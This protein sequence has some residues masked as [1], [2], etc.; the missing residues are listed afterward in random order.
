MNDALLVLALKFI[1]ENSFFLIKLVLSRKI[2]V[3]KRLTLGYYYLYWYRTEHTLEHTVISKIIKHIQAFLLLCQATVTLKL[4][5]TAVFCS[6]K[7]HCE[8]RN[9]ASFN[10]QEFFRSV[11]LETISLQRQ[12]E[13]KTMAERWKD[14]KTK[15]YNKLHHKY[16]S[17]A[18]KLT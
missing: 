2:F 10:S 3:S 16:V 7:F 18:S 9:K 12:K 15:C 6:H 13:R 14:K 8:F 1:T 11:S 5:Y 17:F 4:S